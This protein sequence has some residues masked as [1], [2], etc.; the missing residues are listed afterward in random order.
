MSLKLSSEI[1]DSDSV[2]WVGE[3]LLIELINFN[4]ASF[5]QCTPAGSRMVSGE[6]CIIFLSQN[7][8]SR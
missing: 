1:P 3:D 2:G 6:T 5:T 7:A 8:A 4:L